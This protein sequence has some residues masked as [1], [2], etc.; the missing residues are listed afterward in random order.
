M[1]I[2]ELGG[3]RGSMFNLFPE[4]E[5]QDYPIFGKF[6]QF[7][8]SSLT[9]IC[10]LLTKF[11]IHILTLE[12]YLACVDEF[13][14][15]EGVENQPFACF[16]KNN[17]ESAETTI[18]GVVFTQSLV[19]EFDLTESEQFAA[20]AHE[21]GHIMYFYLDNKD[22]YPNE[23]VYAD[24]IA[25]RI[26]LRYSIISLLDK[27]ISCGRYKDL[28]GMLIMRKLFMSYYASNSDN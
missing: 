7:Y 19:D 24:N 22:S 4:Q 3:V 11:K 5:Q 23:E 18:A 26:G 25:C 21:V 27:L 12:Q 17:T 1:S 15:I 13:P 28:E 20:I 6:C 9:S 16:V 8:G 14:K 10:H 2:S